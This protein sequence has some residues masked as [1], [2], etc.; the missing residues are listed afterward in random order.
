MTE[1]LTESVER[2]EISRR[3]F[4]TAASVGGAALLNWSIIGPAN[5]ETASR[6]PASQ[7]IDLD[8]NWLFGGK[9]LAGSESAA[10]ND[11]EFELVTLPHNVQPL[12]RNR[13][14]QSDWDGQWIYRRHFDVPQSAVKQRVFLDFDGAAVTTEL[15]INGKKLAVH[16]GGFDAF[17]YEITDVVKPGTNILAVRLDCSWQNVPPAGAPGG[18]QE[19]DFF[20]PGGIH[21]SSRLR[22]LPQVF[23]ADVYVRPHD[24]LDPGRRS[25][26]VQVSLN[27]AVALEKDA[28]LI[29][30]I[31]DGDRK[32]AQGTGPT[33]V[34]EAG[35]VTANVAVSGLEDLTLWHVDNPKLYSI[36]TSLKI[37]G[38]VLHTYTTRVGLRDAIFKD[39]GF[40]LNGERLQL[41]GTNRTELYPHLGF[42]APARLKSQ[43]ATILRKTLGC[44][45][46][47]T[48][49]YPQSTEF[50][51]A[52]DE[53]G[54]LVFEEIPGWHWVGSSDPEVTRNRDY[55]ELIKRDA[56]R[57]IVRDRN[58][59]SVVLWGLLINETLEL[60]PYKDL[61]DELDRM[62][63][64]L[65]TRQTSG[66]G[67]GTASPNDWY[68]DV[69]AINDYGGK[70]PDKAGLRPPARTPYIVTEAVGQW[71]GFRTF[72]RRTDEPA[73]Q[74]YQAAN[75]ASV[76]NQA[77]GDPR[78]SGVM[79][80][81][82]WDYPT[83]SGSRLQGNKAGS[84]CDIF[85]NPRT[86]GA[87]YRSTISADVEVTL[88]EDF[89]W[90]V[91]Q[92]QSGG[93]GAKC[94]FYSNCDILKVYVD[95]NLHSTLE[96]DRQTY[97]HLAHPP[98]F[99][100]FSNVNL[101]SKPV[102]RVEGL[103][104]SAVRIDRQYSLDTSKDTITAVL[105]DAEIHGDGSD[106]TR[107]TVQA[108]DEFG[109]LRPFQGGDVSF[110][111]SGPV[112]LIGDNPF[113]WADNG[114]IASVYLRGVA[115]GS[116]AATV[117]ARHARFG[118]ISKAL[119]IRSVETALA[120]P[121]V[122]LTVDTRLVAPGSPITANVVLQ[123]SHAAVRGVEVSL[124][125]PDG[126]QASGAR[127]VGTLG[128][129]ATRELSWT[130]EPSK[131]AKFGLQRIRAVVVYKE[132]DRSYL[133]K[134]T[135]VEVDVAYANLAQAYNNRGTS[136][137]SQP[138]S[139]SGSNFDGTK[140]SFSL[141]ALAAV[142]IRPDQSFQVDGVPV[143]W[144]SPTDGAAG[145][146]NDNVTTFGQTV[147]V[148][149]AE[150]NAPTRLM[151]VGASAA[152]A[153]VGTAR[154]WY[155]DGMSDDVW[156][157]LGDYWSN[158]ILDNLDA[159]SMPYV[160][161]PSGRKEHTVKL[162]SAPVPLARGK[163][164]KAFTLP[165]ESDPLVGRQTVHVFGLGV[166]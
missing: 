112:E 80:W 118:R 50:M 8:S 69:F 70:V 106:A 142:G 66:A 109:N 84:I 81:C 115:G 51:D 166:G 59:P 85:R 159:A 38:Q 122:N 10:W 137:D 30:E 78:Y 39:D 154:V 71:P 162:F 43:D 140:N 103:I 138:G 2:A 160:N 102:L 139:A 33:A 127:R 158:G 36:H 129:Q 117:T 4:L 116:G 91:G 143:V 77:A 146:A 58:R 55:E 131:A 119:R 1:Y 75:H 148:P 114:G 94:G 145:T 27:S 42:A 60:Q 151:V 96:P 28:E 6:G 165:A 68:F 141:E 132:K 98:F 79:T 144:A 156:I 90:Y 134:S 147:L 5:A 74:R 21:R 12:G 41:I 9:Y 17:S 18:P 125:V 23:I 67:R 155:T 110:T 133:R 22:V 45:I 163:K 48:S 13:W 105:D 99:A 126:W 121:V 157:G 130:L 25:L 108:S 95:G 128:P 49:H 57:M 29:V 64:S 73:I 7:T 15:F 37:K 82:A 31:F 26:D 61:W 56:E 88:G 86:A 92:R 72:Y 11:T 34:S 107:L 63:K 87:F 53:L 40:Y 52:C 164:V 123:G 104:G 54:L 14:L 62:A 152:G 101:D 20:I 135:G 161:S 93:P 150:G 97:A 65:D 24:V 47:R 100:D 120:T 35:T 46:A 44:N 76:H 89:Y 83:P 153:P 113:S 149:A 19:I 136:S 111:V 16:Q 124:E 32:L 3:I